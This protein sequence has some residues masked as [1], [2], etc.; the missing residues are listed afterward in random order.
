MLQA[1]EPLF[2]AEYNALSICIISALQMGSRR[3]RVRGDSRLITKQVNEE[4]ALKKTAPD[5]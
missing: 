1:R 2:E 4:L 5:S 3:L